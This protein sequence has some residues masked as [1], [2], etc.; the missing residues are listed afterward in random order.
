[1]PQPILDPQ[2]AQALYDGG[3]ID[4]ATFNRLSGAQSA[5]T[6]P[7]LINQYQHLA[8]MEPKPLPW[9]QAA[10]D[11]VE[12]FLQNHV[13]NP[14]Y[15]AGYENLGPAVGATLSAGADM[16][17]PSTGY[18]FIPAMGTVEDASKGA[19]K[20]VGLF[21]NASENELADALERL[22]GQKR[23]AKDRLEGMLR[24]G[25]GLSDKKLPSRSE[26]FQVVKG[27]QLPK[28][29][30][31][32]DP[33]GFRQFTSRFDDPKDLARMVD[34]H[35]TPSSEPYFGGDIAGPLYRTHP[36][37]LP[38]TLHQV[39]VFQKI[40]PEGHLGKF[41]EKGGADPFAWMD[42]RYGVAKQALID[43]YDKP[44][45][46]STRSDLIAHDDYL[47]HLNPAKHKV[48]I[49]V[50]GDNARAGRVAIPGGPSFQRQLTAAQKLKDAGIDVTIVHDRIKGMN[51]E[52]NGLDQ[53][54]LKKLGFKT[55]ENLINPS[56]AEK[57]NLQKAMGD[58]IWAPERTTQSQKLFDL[59]RELK[60]R[61][62]S[63]T[64]D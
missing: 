30:I 37:A 50:F 49:H 33:E 36:Q 13:V 45:K 63:N 28:D 52:L 22:Y 53:L 20:V 3:H 2:T 14:L 54:Q 39:P 6:S 9:A 32:D 59:D 60:N 43:N 19:G 1:M 15:N 35:K 40:D 27:A 31:V 61:G 17:L 62:P 12:S 8:D 7:D 46:I 48:E 44:L 16:V 38:G 18:D 56:Q 26:P 10:R 47:E 24:F 11:K 64:E 41:V 5:Q 55:R 58:N 34:I 29:I 51:P 57:R 23:V 25:E 4:E 42:G 21:K